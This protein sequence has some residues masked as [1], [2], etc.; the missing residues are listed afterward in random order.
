M[1]EGNRKGYVNILKEGLVY[2][3]WLSVHG[4]GRQQ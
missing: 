1:P 4:S 2:A 3:A